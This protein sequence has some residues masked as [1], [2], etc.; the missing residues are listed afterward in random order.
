[1]VWFDRIFHSRLTNDIIWLSVKQFSFFFFF[2]RV[3]T[4]FLLNITF[5]II[6]INTCKAQKMSV[7]SLQFTTDHH[8]C[9]LFWLK[10]PCQLLKDFLKN[11]L[12]KFFLLIPHFFNVYRSNQIN[13]QSKLFVHLGQ[14]DILEYKVN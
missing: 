13:H 7:N 5:N 11:Q 4:L 12:W 14:R 10:S 3:S 1:M 9:T 2:L 8:L 6:L